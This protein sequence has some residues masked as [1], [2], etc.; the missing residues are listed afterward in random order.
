M[1]T[2]AIEG[3]KSLA[4]ALP[5]VLEDPLSKAVRSHALYGAWLCATCLGHVGMSLHHKP[6]HTLG[7]SFNLPHA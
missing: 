4:N 6:C 2:H 7:G 3:V 5:D 1:N